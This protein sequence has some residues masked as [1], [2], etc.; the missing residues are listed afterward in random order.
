MNAER[1]WGDATA[2]RASDAAATS[3]L[4][5]DITV[6]RGAFVLDAALTLAPGE[7]LAL[8]G[9]NG[10]GKSTLLAAIAGLVRPGSGHV[11]AGGRVLSRMPVAPQSAR[12]VAPHPSDTQ[13]WVEPAQR[14]IGLLGQDPLLFP[15]LN[16]AANVAYGLLAQGVPR[17]R[18]LE[19]AREWLDAV[20]LAGL[21]RRRPHALSGG[22]QQRV[23][24]ARALAARP[25]VLLL[26]EPMAALDVQTAAATRELLA[27]R[28]RE[29]GTTAIMVTHDV[30]D[31]VAL[32][33]RVAVLSQGRIV[34]DGSPE[35]VLGERATP[36]AS[37]LAGGRL[38]AGI[39]GDDGLVRL[40]R[41]EG[42]LPRGTRVWLI[43]EARD[44][45]SSQSFQ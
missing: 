22:Q 34:D 9:P 37:A 18:A 11:S 6:R 30:L 19:R 43:A 33:D 3:A 25:S 12:P 32:A 26:D 10:S 38:V 13:V 23:A 41:A 2:E 42:V 5:A 8:L 21:E 29:T 31:V 20:G 24:I 17:P 45:S 40:E 14:S 1:A 35:R 15:H 16:A 39:V 27:E 7:V 28:I 4:D 44:A 36:F